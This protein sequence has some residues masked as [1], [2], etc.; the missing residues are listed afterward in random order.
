MMMSTIREGLQLGGVVVL[1]FVFVFVSREKDDCGC[2][3]QWR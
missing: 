1:F 3:I 2:G